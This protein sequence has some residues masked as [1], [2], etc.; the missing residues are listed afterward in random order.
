MFQKMCTNEREEEIEEDDN[1]VRPRSAPRRESFKGQR[2][3]DSQLNEQERKRLESMK[4]NEQVN[5]N[6]QKK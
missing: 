1:K 3:V 4:Q 6:N 5:L 2:L